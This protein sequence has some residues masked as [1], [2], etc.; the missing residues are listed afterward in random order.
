MKAGGEV[1]VTEK[2]AERKTDT[3]I[4]SERDRDLNEL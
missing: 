2:R 1:R 3:E 4:K